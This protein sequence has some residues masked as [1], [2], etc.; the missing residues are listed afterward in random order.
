MVPSRSPQPARTNPS[1]IDKSSNLLFLIMLLL[2]SLSVKKILITDWVLPLSFFQ[3]GDVFL[4][5][6]TQ[7]E[8]QKVGTFWCMMARPVNIWGRIAEQK[9]EKSCHSGFPA[10]GN[11]EG[12]F[13]LSQKTAVGLEEW[14][15]TDWSGRLV[16]RYFAKWKRE[17]YKYFGRRFIRIKP[18]QLNLFLQIYM[19]K[20]LRNFSQG[21]TGIPS[22]SKD[23]WPR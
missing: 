8:D 14:K 23:C 2:S 17:R 16:N 10:F 19:A 9:S 18:S 5:K 22:I 11:S 21:I 1:P 20:L 7:G 6:L 15:R 3:L 13:S 12:E 4:E